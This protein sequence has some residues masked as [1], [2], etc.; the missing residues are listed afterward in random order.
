MNPVT[1]L[2][3]ILIDFCHCCSR[4]VKAAVAAVAEHLAGLVE[5]QLT[6]SHAHQNTAQVCFAMTHCESIYLEKVAFMQITV[7]IL[8]NILCK[9]AVRDTTP[10][11]YAVIIRC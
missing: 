2:F 9:R 7:S 3:G 4:P 8:L 1:S 6:Y 11:K 10:W 5:T